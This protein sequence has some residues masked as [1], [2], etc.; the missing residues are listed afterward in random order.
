MLLTLGLTTQEVGARQQQEGIILRKLLSDT[1]EVLY[2]DTGEALQ[3]NLETEDDMLFTDLMPAKH[4]STLINDTVDSPTYT[5]FLLFDEELPAGQYDFV[6]NFVVNSPDTND[7]L[8]WRIFTNIGEYP[9]IEFSFEAKDTSDVVP[10]NFPLRLTHLGGTME[11]TL[12]L[13]KEDAQH[14]DCE[15]LGASFY[16]HRVG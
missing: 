8:Y 16:L 2:T 14:K 15:V 3:H 11:W 4:N 7:S 1:G 9:N 12:Q 6:V 13:R 5:D 10:V